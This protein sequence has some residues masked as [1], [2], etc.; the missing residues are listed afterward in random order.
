MD[1]AAA[2]AVP[3]T[4]PACLGMA[5]RRT[6]ITAADKVHSG[7]VCT[8]LAGH[9]DAHLMWQQ[10]MFIPLV[11]KTSRKRRR[12]RETE[13]LP[14]TLKGVLTASLIACHSGH[15]LWLQRV[16]GVQIGMA[17]SL[18]STRSTHKRAPFFRRCPYSK[19]FLMYENLDSFVCKHLLNHS[20]WM[21]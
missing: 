7:Q 11:L 13:A 3:C 8:E 2:F 5:T 4:S 10:Y 6:H 19:A 17:D 12:V 18:L 16:W 15:C 21:L 9:G 1:S 14:R 20:R